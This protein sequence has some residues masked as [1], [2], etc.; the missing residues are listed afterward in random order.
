MKGPADILIVEDD[1]EFGGILTRVVKRMGLNPLLATSI[2]DAAN[3]LARNKI[4]LVLLDR[5]LGKGADGLTLCLALKKAPQTRA[6][7]VIVVTGLSDAGGECKGYR[8]GAD[9]YLR[10]P[11]SLLNLARYI[12]A[13]L[14][15]LP[16]KDE[17]KG[18]IAYDNIFLDSATRTVSI[19]DQSYPNLPARQF[20]F[21][22]LLASRK[23]TPVSRAYL[24]KELWNN[25]VRDKEVDVLVSRLKKRLGETAAS[26]IVPVRSYGYR[27]RPLPPA[28]D[29]LQ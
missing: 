2:M 25:P 9:L 12:D 17:L 24:I 26:C 5:R 14:D 6:I 27:M 16:Y 1:R 19:G 10:K 18:R 28:K 23:G 20:D 29:P 13:F 22:A 11:F 4:R 21:I 8:Y 3:L 7:P 15:R